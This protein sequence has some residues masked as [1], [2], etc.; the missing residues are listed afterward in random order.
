MLTLIRLLVGAGRDP[1][2]RRTPEERRAD[3][4]ASYLT[5]DPRDIRLGLSR[6]LFDLAD[7]GSS[8]CWGPSRAEQ[9][10]ASKEINDLIASFNWLYRLI[11]PLPG[12]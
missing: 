12:S 10:H 3:F 11:T 8:V 7:I 2:S 6:R 5:L 9:E 4:T 1:Q